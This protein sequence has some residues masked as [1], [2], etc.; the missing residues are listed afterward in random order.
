MQIVDSSCFLVGPAPPFSPVFGRKCSQ[1]VPKFI[2]PVLAA[3]G[4]RDHESQH[5][6]AVP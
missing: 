1:V 6:F 4:Q 2:D 3:N 5:V